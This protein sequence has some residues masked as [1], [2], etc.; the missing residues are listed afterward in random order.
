MNKKIKIL[1][2]ASLCLNI[3]FAGLM[4]RRFIHRAFEPRLMGGFVE[5]QRNSLEEIRREKLKALDILQNETFNE[6]AY[7]RQVDRIS[8]LQQKMFKD[9][10]M[11]MGTKLRTLPSDE[12]DKI[13]G[14]MKTRRFFRR[15]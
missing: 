14:R 5:Q 13:I 9:F 11:E 2:I 10:A 12:R 1:L 8:G 7:S 4:S 6:D 3:F 15:P